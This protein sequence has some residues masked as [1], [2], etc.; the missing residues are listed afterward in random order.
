M[1]LVE[2]FTNAESGAEGAALGVW[3]FQEYKNKDDQSNNVKLDLYES[4]DR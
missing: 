3:K 1:I 2:G 4:L